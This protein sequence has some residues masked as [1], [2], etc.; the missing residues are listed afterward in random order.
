ME[1]YSIWSY[2]LIVWSGTRSRRSLFVRMPRVLVCVRNCSKVLED[3]L[4]MENISKCY[5]KIISSFRDGLCKSPSLADMR[6]Y[7]HDSR[8]RSSAYRRENVSE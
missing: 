8:T 5:A 6:I 7:L 2:S 4:C 3:M 1:V